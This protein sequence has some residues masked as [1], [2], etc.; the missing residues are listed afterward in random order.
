MKKFLKFFKNEEIRSDWLFVVDEKGKK[1]GKLSK[2][3][4]IKMA[5]RENK[6]V[7]LVNFDASPPVAKIIE[8]GKFLYQQ[9]KKEGK[10][11]R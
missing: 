2:E 1:I 5:Q 6:D 3:E 8:Y 9:R 4:A 7:V 11:K 10:Q